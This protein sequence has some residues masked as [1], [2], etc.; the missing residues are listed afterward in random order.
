MKMTID[1]K[2]DPRVSDDAVPKG[3]GNLTTHLGTNRKRRMEV[4]WQLC[5]QWNGRSTKWVAM[6]Y[7]IQSYNMETPDYPVSNDLV[8]DLEI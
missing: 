4:S 7:L 2:V 5:I 8:D 3:E 1:D 6:K